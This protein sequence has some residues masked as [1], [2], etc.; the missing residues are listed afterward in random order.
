MFLFDLFRSFLPL[1]NPLGFGVSDFLLLAL[2]MLLAVCAI[3]FARLQPLALRLASHTRWSMLVAAALPVLLRLALLPRFPAP[4]PAG[5]DDF[6]Y[7]LLAD[8]LRHLR[9]ANP[10][11]PLHRFFEAVFV[12]QEP[13]YSSIFPPGQG[14]ALALGW[15]IFGHPWAGVVLIDRGILRAVLLDAA[16]LDHAGLGARGRVAGG[17]SN[18]ARST[19]G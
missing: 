10:V 14:L 19:S 8:T 6:A 5:A 9:L 13:S 11:H 7:L 17:L 4:S 15:A 16:R 18:S 12:L 1:H 3:G 2:A